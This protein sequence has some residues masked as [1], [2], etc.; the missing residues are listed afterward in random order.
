MVS[1][2]KILALNKLIKEGKKEELI[3]ELKKIRKQKLERIDRVTLS[4]IYDRVSEFQ[5]AFI[6]LGS[7]NIS[8]NSNDLKSDKDLL[9]YSCLALKL[10]NFG[11]KYVSLKILKLIIE[12]QNKIEVSAKTNKRI[13]FYLA[14]IYYSHN[15]HQEAEKIFRKIV[16]TSQKKT[17]FLLAAT[18]IESGKYKEAEEIL[19]HLETLSDSKF[20][21]ALTQLDLGA[22]YLLQN[23]DEAAERSL[24]KAYSFL[25]SIGKNI[26]LVYYFKWKS[27]LE[28]KQEKKTASIKSL[29]NAISLVRELGH[30]PSIYCDLLDCKKKIG[31][32]LDREEKIFYFSYFEDI[33][34][35]GK[36]NG[37][38]LLCLEISKDKVELVTYS[39]AKLSSNV[40]DLVSGIMIQNDKKTMLKTSLWRL[41]YALTSSASIGVGKF[42]LADYVYQNNLVDLKR[43]T[44]N[45]HKMTKL[46][47]AD[48]LEIVLEDSIYKGIR[49]EKTTILLPLSRQEAKREHLYQKYS[50]DKLDLKK[51]CKEFDLNLVKFK[52]MI[53]NEI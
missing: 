6:I 53:K 27:L 37:D 51:L 5:E 41:L 29:S 33:P 17:Q 8:F 36:T 7:K 20:I 47:P 34:Q 3:E 11:A 50:L 13:L 48:I 21:L 19:V 42:A 9:F 44:M 2:E 45:L 49:E 43:A 38:E 25:S 40:L 10:S 4:D 14:N 26:D 52:T 22:T 39:K 32:N 24:E 31:Q 30:F 12:M 28:F 1:N 23:K 15:Y 18:L 16:N 46:V 35:K